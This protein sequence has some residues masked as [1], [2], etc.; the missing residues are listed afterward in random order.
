MIVGNS[1]Q[2]PM[3][4]FELAELLAV[5]RCEP[6]KKCSTLL[7][8]DVCLEMSSVRVSQDGASGTWWQPVLQIFVLEPLP[9]FSP[10]Q[11]FSGVTLPNKVLLRKVK[12]SKEEPPPKHGTE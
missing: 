11:L 2:V 3:K 8:L 4:G 7:P 1:D 10:L 12:W 5:K 9:H 6:V